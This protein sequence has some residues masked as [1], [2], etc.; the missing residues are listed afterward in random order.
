MKK[1]TLFLLT[2]VGLV[3]FIG[4]MLAY[5][6]YQRQHPEIFKTNEQLQQEYGV[7]VEVVEVSRRNIISQERFTGTV[8]GYSETLV[9]SDLTQKVLE[10][11]VKVGDRVSR[12]DTIAVLD[13]KSVSNMNLKYD[14]TVMAYRDA[15]T[16]FERIKNLYKA[17][18][19]AKQAYDKAKLKYEISKSN[20]EAITSA[21][22]IRSPINGI[23]TE[24]YVE[25]GDRI[26]AGRPVAKVV[27]FDK[28]KIKVPVSEA[29]IGRVKIGQKCMVKTT[30]I[31]HPSKGVVD[32]V[33]L[34]AD[35]RSRTFEI[36]VVVDNPDLELRSGM[37]ATVAILFAERTNVPAI[38]KDALLKAD[39]RYWVYTVSKTDSLLSKQ[40]ITPG[41]F[42]GQY[43]E[44]LSGLHPGEWVVVQGQN[45]IL[46]DHQKA[47]IIPGE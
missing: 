26:N 19:I 10:L 40:P 47:R 2:L 20:L 37:Y 29:E 34:S 3:V 42:D 7:P 23:V 15:K 24:T 46:R 39:S 32:E 18:A 43:Y 1:R 12:H 16:D 5:R 21:V 36:T 41:A 27:R 4:L 17:G 44:I 28:V 30:S 22:F 9:L 33:S 38:P 6:V 31:N 45:N 25:P 8:E 35:P 14:Q 11:R 13:R